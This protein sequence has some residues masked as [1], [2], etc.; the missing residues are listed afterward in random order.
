MRDGLSIPQFGLGV[1]DMSAKQTYAAVRTALSAGYKHVDTAEWYYNEADVGRALNDHLKETG[2]DRSDYFVT[3]KLMR[4]RSYAA[5]LAD[6]RASLERAKLDYFDLYLLHSPIGGPAVRS[7]VW[8]AL[9]DAKAEG[10]VRSIGVSN[11]GV[12]HLDEITT[13]LP[14]VNQVD[15]H[16]WMRHEDIVAACEARGILL[17]AWA[18][19]ARGLKFDDPALVRIAKK[20]GR[21]KAQVLLR[22]GLQHGFIV[23]PKSVSPARI[24][25][26]AE[27]FDFVLDD[28]DM[29]ALDG[30]DEYLVTDWDVVDVE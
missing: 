6:L 10:L 29:Q 24:A 1:Y 2:A 4:N 15:L 27:V 26:N 8:R 30:L 7:E 5:A 22:W 19:L 18:P 16:P 21:D 17:E 3:S 20:H 14:A 28:E 25:S 12:R 13:E 23:I 9:V 11:F